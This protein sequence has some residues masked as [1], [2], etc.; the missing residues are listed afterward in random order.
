MKNFKL[1]MEAVAEELSEEAC[2]VIF[3]AI[4]G[5]IVYLCF[6]YP[7]IFILSLMILTY[8]VMV[9]I[10]QSFSKWSKKVM[11]KYKQLKGENNGKI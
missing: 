1:F 3:L 5:F 6:I 10:I 7:I 11:K 2:I 9:E 4:M 8:L